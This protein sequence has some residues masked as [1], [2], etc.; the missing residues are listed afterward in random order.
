MERLSAAKRRKHHALSTLSKISG[1][2]RLSVWKVVSNV[3]IESLHIE[4]WKRRIDHLSC[5]GQPE[6][7]EVNLFVMF[8]D[9]MQ[10]TIKDLLVERK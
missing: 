4:F 7:V 5:F 10:D 8:C 1:Y 9:E 2:P 3:L 6:A